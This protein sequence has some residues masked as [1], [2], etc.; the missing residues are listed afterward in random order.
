MND[1]YARV[2]K[3]VESLGEHFDSVQIFVTLHEPTKGG[4]IAICNGSGNWHARYGQ[5]RGWVIR[6]D[7]GFRAAG[8]E[9]GGA[10]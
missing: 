9:G 4:T 10:I 7:E 6:E 5:V 3:A 8:R 2:E 1:D